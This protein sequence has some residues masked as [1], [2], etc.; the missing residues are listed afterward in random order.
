M[1]VANMNRKL[2]RILTGLMWIAIPL[3][4][5]RYWQVWDELPASMATHFAADGYPNGWMSREIAL[6]YAL[7]V[8]AFILIVFTGLA[9]VVLKQKAKLDSTSFALI[10]F[11]YA[12]VGFVF[13]VNN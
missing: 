8:T 3:T 9:V 1:K 7:G 5:L 11:F 13:Y 4:A 12:I 10:G 6:Y 2:F